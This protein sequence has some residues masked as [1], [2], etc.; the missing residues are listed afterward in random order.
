MLAAARHEDRLDVVEQDHRSLLGGGEARLGMSEEVENS[1][2]ALAVARARDLGTVDEGEHHRRIVGGRPKPTAKLVGEPLGERGLAGARRSAE[3]EALDEA[4]L[5]AGAP[6]VLDDLRQFSQEA[7]IALAED[8]VALCVEQLAQVVEMQDIFGR[9]MMMMA[10]HESRVHP[11]PRC[12]K[13][14]RRQLAAF[15]L[16]N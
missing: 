2:L 14:A 13:K 8:I 16:L 3:Q 10:A 9:D 7:K 15:L 11:A 1:F 4:A 6:L 5:D 12:V